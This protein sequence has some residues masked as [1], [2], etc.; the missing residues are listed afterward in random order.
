MTLPN[1][2]TAQEEARLTTLLDLTDLAPRELTESDPLP[3][4]TAQT[5]R[6]PGRSARA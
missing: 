4:E 5:G 3:A 2:G 6:M 1:P